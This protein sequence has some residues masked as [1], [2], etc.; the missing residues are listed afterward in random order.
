MIHKGGASLTKIADSDLENIRMNSLGAVIDYS[1][2]EFHAHQ[3]VSG[4]RAVK[5]SRE[6]TH[7]EHP[8]SRK[9]LSVILSKARGGVR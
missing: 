4:G 5:E 7:Y 9:I 6:H 3:L 2:V 8:T 1:Q